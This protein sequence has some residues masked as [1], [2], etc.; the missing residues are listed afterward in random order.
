MK[1]LPK[2]IEYKLLSYIDNTLSEVE[3]SEFEMLLQN[4][5]DVQE[6]LKWLTKAESLVSINLEEP[7]RNFTNV[8]MAR[9]NQSPDRRISFR[10]SFFLLGGIVLTVIICAVLVSYGVFDSTASIDLNDMV[11]KNNF[12]KNSL[13]TIPFNGKMIVNIIIILNLILAFVVLDKTILK[14]FFENRSKIFE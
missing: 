8:I 4:N 13:P 12:I 9:L 3:R 5:P 14:P 2:D 7:P 1:E 10:N 6:K 11:I